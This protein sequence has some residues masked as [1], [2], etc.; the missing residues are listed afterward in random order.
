MWYAKRVAAR[1][2]LALMT[3]FVS[4][5]ASDAQPREAGRQAALRALTAM[6]GRARPA[7]A[8]VLATRS[9]D[10]AEAVPEGVAAVLGPI[11]VVGGTAGSAVFD[12]SG[13]YPRGV[14]VALLGGDVV[15]SP[16][17]QAAIS[18]SELQEV[19]P[20]AHQ[21]REA[22]D[23]AARDGYGEALCL[24][25]APGAKVDGESLAAALGKGVG[26]RVQL[27]GALTGGETPF[28]RPRVFTRDGAWN[29]RVVM[30]GF[31]T[32]APAGIVARHGWH[33][34]A[35]TR[36]VTRSEGS[37]L[38]E[39]DERP[40]LERWLGDT[41]GAVGYPVHPQDLLAA[42]LNRYAFGVDVPSRSEPLICCPLEFREDGS[43]RVAASVAEGVRA[44]LMHG[45][46]PGVL[47]AARRAA[48]L[49]QER[50]SGRTAG[51]LVF[52]C[53]KR[54]GAMGP[55]FA[56]ESQAIAN[57]LDAP[58]A[59]ACVLGEIACARGE[60]DAFHNMSVVV[61]AW[62]AAPRSR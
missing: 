58:A 16:V 25:F 34:V 53:Q 13:V 44:C 60:V 33:A 39:L 51:A 26:G 9:Y 14:L 35:P 12:A 7:L 11:P 37:W 15:T 62:P 28:D 27:A 20:A 32:R 49:A 17:Y 22:A 41:S 31:F 50:A 19:V 8:V 40:A 36:T 61:V 6:N 43:V 48:R 59:G 24:A 45:E 29:D 4:A 10:D 42:P 54:F 56:N 21:V 30:V 2:E 5:I 52:T 46:A 47:D 57:A 1:A 23:R 55:H 38:V 3:T 18:S